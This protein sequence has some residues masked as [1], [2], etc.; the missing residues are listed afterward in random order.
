[1]SGR[2]F[3]EFEIQKKHS[4]LFTMPILKTNHVFYGGDYNPEQWSEEV[5]EQDV[6][7]MREARVNLVSLAIFSWAKLEPS[8][9]V[10]T[11]EWLDRIIN[12]LHANGVAVDL[13][14][15]TASP[16]AWLARLHPESL[17]QDENGMRYSPGGRQHYC[18][19]S[20]AFRAAAAAITRRLAERY[21]EHP[22]VVMWHISN[23]YSCHIQGCYCDTCAAAFRGWLRQKYG[24]LDRLNEIWGTA[25]WSQWYSDW[26]EILPP[27][28]APTF[29]NPCQQVDYRHF[30]S[31]SVLAL[32]QAEKAIVT[33]VTPNLPVTTNFMG[34]AKGLDFYDWGSH[35]DFACWDSYPDPLEGLTA[36]AQNAAAH[37]LMR[38]TKAGAPFLLMEQVTSQV[39]W[40]P[41]NRLKRPGA[42]RTGSY[43]ALARGADG[44]LFF[45]WRAA[46]AGA[47]KYHGAMVPHVGPDKSRIFK[48][49]C[50]LGAELEKLGEVAG[51]RV[52][53]EVAIVFDW[54][55]WWAVELDSKP[56]K[57]DYIA[58]VCEFHR[59][60]F[61]ANIAVDF[62]SVK[63][64]WSKYKFVIAPHLYQIGPDAAAAIRSYVTGGGAFLTN[65]F[66]GIT[67]TNE[68][69]QL[70]GYPALIKDVLGMWVEEWDPHGPGME[71]GVQW[72]DKGPEKVSRA[73]DLSEVIHADGAEVLAVFQSEFYKGLPAVT[74]NRFG[75]GLAYYLGTRLDPDSLGAWLGSVCR[76]LGVN[77]LVS[78]PEGVEAALRKS[79][80]RQ[81]LILVNH[82]PTAAAV[83]LGQWIG[84]DLL[85]GA[86]CHGTLE[87]EPYGVRVIRLTT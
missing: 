21:A 9:G 25:F 39:N 15:A 36:I 45:Q 18:P 81:F 71:N 51:S 83:G 6:R 77:P 78:A 53:A 43:Q 10:Y 61:D 72:K 11:F 19:N 20:T 84:T 30:F 31:D 42:M 41:A 28:K 34:F 29:C 13:A 59:A 50:E 68:H 87:M 60:F 63:G 80:D 67:D 79:D 22:G 32:Y 35:V 66:S 40:R 14:T 4:T 23:E 62:V 85:S 1:M 55:N 86:K 5:W 70:G 3:A 75:T 82:S 38:S 7:L 58:R 37:D 46:K 57:I 2:L 27:R 16:P 47:E 64:D 33:E 52:Q 65:Y 74:R 8:P 48:E 26:E 54:P 12:L 24:T 76:E 73:L 49:V 17:P 44:I 69:I 56:A